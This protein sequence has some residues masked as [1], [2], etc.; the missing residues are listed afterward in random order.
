MLAGADR[1]VVLEDLVDTTNVGAIFRSAAALGW[2]AVLLTA[3]CADP[4]YRRAVRTSMGA[5][6]SLPWTRIDHRYGMEMLR[7][8]GLTVVALTPAAHDRP[9]LGGAADRA[10]RC[11]SA[12]RARGLSTR[13]WTPRICACGSRCAARSIR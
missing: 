1:V 12:A 13:G 6:F 7:D 11:S 5:V 3:R 9:R 2:D 8:A 4:L 10:V